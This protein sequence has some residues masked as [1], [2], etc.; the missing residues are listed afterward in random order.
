LMNFIEQFKVIYSDYKVKR[1]HFKFRH[2]KQIRSC[3]IVV[4][5]ESFVDRPESYDLFNAK[6]FIF[7]AHEKRARFGVYF[8]IPI[9]NQPQSKVS[10]YSKE[11]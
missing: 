9:H 7:L 4:L 5:R 1:I 3:E 11:V 2:R 6:I 8:A 10:K